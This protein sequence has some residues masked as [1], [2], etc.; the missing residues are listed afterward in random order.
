MDTANLNAEAE[1]G[2]GVGGRRVSCLRLADDQKTA[3]RCGAAIIFRDKRPGRTWGPTGKAP[4]LRRVASRWE[5]STIAAVTVSNQVFK[6]TYQHSVRAQEVVALLRH[7]G[8][9]GPDKAE[10]LSPCRSR[11]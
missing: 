9:H 6:C 3:R 10:F 1:P 4:I 8:R 2:A 11:P 5:L 7:L